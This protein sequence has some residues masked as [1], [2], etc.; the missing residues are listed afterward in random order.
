[1]KRPPFFPSFLL[2]LSA[3]PA[4][5]DPSA[6]APAREITMKECV[7]TALR[8][9]IEIAVSRTEKEIGEWG[10]PIEEAAFFPRFTAELGANRSILPSG[11]VLDNS[12]SVEQRYYTFELGVSDLLRTGTALSLAFESQRQETDSA[13]F[14]LTPEYRTAL[15]LKAQQPLLKNF[16][17]KV[18]E[19]PLEIARAGASEK[20]EEWNA[21]VMDIVAAVRTA[22]LAF[23]D[24]VRAV[25]VRRGALELAER[26]LVQ[27]D[28][29]IDAGAMAPMDRLPAEAAVASRREDL[30]RAEAAAQGASDDLKNVLGFRT[31]AEWEETL[32]PAPMSGEIPAPG[33]GETFEEAVRRRPEFPAQASRQFQAEIREMIARNRLLPSLDLSLSAGLSGL[34][35]EENPNS[36]IPSAPGA[37]SGGY[38]ESIDQ[39]FSGR[40]YSW[41]VGLS[42]EIPWRFDREKA[43]WSRAR[44]ATEQQR[45][46]GEALTA[47]IRMEVRKGRR[48]LE[49]ALARI[50]ASRASAAAAAKKLEAEEK[51]LELGRSTVFQV[52]QY[53]QD[54]SEARLAEVRARTDAY[55]A[56]TRL[57]R[58]VGTILEK[59]GIAV[60]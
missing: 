13:V 7:E 45:L 2:L 60:R 35:G 15:T 18:T 26:L 24:A 11:S 36:L 19:A 21:K 46:T 25:E 4:L 49:S 31:G 43:E 54:F 17:R 1:M 58:A 33:A 32:L 6:A 29:R 48:D 51:K 50:E 44:A 28:A 8:N 3:V 38:G 9:N 47:R 20:T 12:L 39:A 27:T 16:G 30:L 42:T 53:Q 14:L 55:D 34:S 56:Q 37:F 52:L 57:W 40:Y 22:F 23:H 59:E 10:V 41:F 5:A